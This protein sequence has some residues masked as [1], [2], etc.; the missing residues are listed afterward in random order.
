MTVFHNP[1]RVVFTDDYLKSLESLLGRRKAVLVT[2]AGWKK[3]GVIREIK[4]ALGKR[5]A[6]VLHNIQPNP[7]LRSID[8]LAGKAHAMRPKVFIALGGGSVIDTTKAVS[9]SM[10]VGTPGWLEAHFRKGKKFPRSFSPVPII[11]VPTT[12]GTGSEVTM[13]ATLWDMERKMKFSLSH[14]GLYPE[15]ALMDV[16][17]TLSAPKRLMAHTALDS[18]SHAFEALWN[19]NANPVSD[20]LALE[21]ASLI[22]EALPEAYA[23]PRKIGA[24]RMLQRASTLSGLAFSNT[25]TALAHSIS[26][27]LTLNYGMPHGLACSFTL[28]EVLR[29]NIKAGPDRFAA[30]ASRLGCHSPEGL[31]RKL[32]RL[33]HDVGAFN[34]LRAY[35]DKEVQLDRLKDQMVTLE[36]VGNN[37]RK[38]TPEEILQIVK[39]S[40]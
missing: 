24:R 39:R 19:V 15:T 14:P 6:G 12:A 35:L 34:D 36:R 1:V 27:P 16:R 4:K 32:K 37:I 38:A 8:A 23:K 10:A 21:A 22:M 17:L 11:A 33:L 2:S 7:A 20:S 3:R 9:A 5:L 31:A 29:W 30:I 18:L 26:Y 13:W 40:L 25:R 28:P